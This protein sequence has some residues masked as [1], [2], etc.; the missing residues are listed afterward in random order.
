MW[1]SFNMSLYALKRR[2]YSQG[3]YVTSYPTTDKPYTAIT[4]NHLAMQATEDEMHRNM[5]ARYV[6]KFG[7]NL[8]N[9]DVGQKQARVR[10]SDR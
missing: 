9:K 10:E 3:T 1:H 7:A 4:T 6:P 8:G 2:E 5:N